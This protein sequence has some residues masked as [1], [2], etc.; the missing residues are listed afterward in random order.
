MSPRF[1]LAT[2]TVVVASAIAMV[3]PAAAAPRTDD[4]LVQVGTFAYLTQPDFR[5]LA[6]IGSVLTDETLGLGTFDNLDGEFVMVG[7]RAYQVKTDGVPRPVDPDLRTPFLQAVRFQPERSGP[8]PP[9]TRCDQLT[10][11]ID[12]LAGSTDRIVAVRVRG[13]FSDL[14]AR[15]VSPVPPPFKPL[16]E[17]VASQTV[18]P[19]GSV[20]AVL[21]GFRQG[22]TALGVGQPGLHL[23]GLTASHNAGGHILSCAAGPDVQITI[24]TVPQV[25]LATP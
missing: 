22:T 4:D 7:G 16:A 19:R 11:I 18:F 21:V 20:R 6:A 13:T 2:L 3:L 25:R 9:G 14:E 15:S 17:V 23:H 10:P 1:R 12:T 8:V 24:D 5:G